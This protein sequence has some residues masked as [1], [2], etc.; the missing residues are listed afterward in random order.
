MDRLNS[1]RRVLLEEVRARIESLE[2]E[3]AA[4]TAV[5]ERLR[6]IQGALDSEPLWGD[7]NEEARDACVV[8]RDDEFGH[9]TM[10]QAAAE[11]LTRSCRPMHAK[12]IWFLVMR[13][14]YPHH[15]KTSFQALVTCMN[16]LKSR[17]RRVAPNTFAI[18]AAADNDER[19]STAVE[20][21]ENVETAVV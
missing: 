11:V 1:A 10:A 2:Y 8:I 4:R 20:V 6:S 17:F 7:A 19:N 15:S 18:V 12:D 14:G 21:R 16:R 13:G 5:I 9:L 3:V